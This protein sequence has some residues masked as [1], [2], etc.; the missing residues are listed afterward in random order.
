MLNIFFFF[1]K[2]RSFTLRFQVWLIYIWQKHAFD[3][4]DS[5]TTI[6]TPYIINYSLLVSQRHFIPMIIHHGWWPVSLLDLTT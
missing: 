1:L 2:A 6:V 4:M 3:D 5:D